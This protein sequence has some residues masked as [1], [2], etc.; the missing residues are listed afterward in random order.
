MIENLKEQSLIAQRTVFDAVSFLGGIEKTE[1]TK[2]MLN[3]VQTSHA[4]YRQCLEEKKKTT[5]EATQKLEEKRKNAI[6]EQQ[7][8]AKKLKLV[9]E[10]QKLLSE[11]D[12]RLKELKEPG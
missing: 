7:I 2:K 5:S 9:E 10:T 12:D 8:K 4:R 3:C 1:I 11:M 6:E